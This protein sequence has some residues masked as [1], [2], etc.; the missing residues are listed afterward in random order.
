MQRWTL[1]KTR[2]TKLRKKHSVQKSLGLAITSLIRKSKSLAALAGLI[3]SAVSAPFPVPAIAT[4]S[5]STGIS[6]ASAAISVISTHTFVPSPMSLSVLAI[7]SSGSS[8]PK[9]VRIALSA[10]LSAWV[11]VKIFALFASISFLNSSF[12]SNF[13]GA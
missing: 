8:V 13:P 11:P 7:S 2:L 1:L 3:R 10:L 5:L 6:P 9:F 4:T 12:N